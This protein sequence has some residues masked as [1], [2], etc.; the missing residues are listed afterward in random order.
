MDSSSS[1][2]FAEYLG[3]FE[4]AR[5]SS[6]INDSTEGNIFYDNETSFFTTTK[7]DDYSSL[8]VNNLIPSVMLFSLILLHSYR[9]LVTNPKS[10]A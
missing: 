8:A 4:D 7:W 10:H 6:D 3:C 9:L 2:G 5:N 1:Y